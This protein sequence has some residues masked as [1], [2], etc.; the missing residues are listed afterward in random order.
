MLARRPSTPP[1]H[2]FQAPFPLRPHEPV[3]STTPSE[4]M[5][6]KLPIPSEHDSGVTHDLLQKIL[7]TRPSGSLTKLQLA[8]G[9]NSGKDKVVVMKGSS[10][11]ASGKSMLS[12]A[13]SNQYAG[14]RYLQV[15]D[16]VD[17]R[18]SLQRSQ[19]K[20]SIA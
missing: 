12:Y 8:S 11:S 5:C 3:L 15:S 2:C 14:F 19:K 9:G 18:V 4:T 17:L 10:E 1:F 20:T 6:R 7:K 13:E 16:N